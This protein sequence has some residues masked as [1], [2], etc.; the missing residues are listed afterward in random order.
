LFHRGDI[1]RPWKSNLGPWSVTNF[2]QTQLLMQIHIM[3]TQDDPQLIMAP[4]KPFLSMVQKSAIDLYNRGL[5]VFPVCRPEI[6]IALANLFPNRW[7]PN[8]KLPFLLQR[9]FFSRL[10]LCNSRCTQHQKTSGIICRG[11]RPGSRFVDLFD[12]TNLGVMLGRTSGNLVCVDCD[13]QIAFQTMLKEFT[14]RGLNFW[15]YNT[16]RGGNLLFRLAEGEAANAKTCSVLRVEI[17]GHRHFCVLPPSIHSSGVVYTWLDFTDPAWHL[18][19]NEPPPILHIEQLQWLGIELYEDRKRSINLF[20]LPDWTLALSENNRRILASEI[21]EGARNTLLTKAVYDIAAAIIDGMV[22]YPEAVALLDEAASRCLPPYPTSSIHQMLRTALGKKDIAP[23][24]QYYSKGNPNLIREPDMEGIGQFQETYDWKSHGRTAL[25]DRSVFI[26]CI[27]RSRREGSI[28]FRA[29]A[30]EIANLANIQDPHT[31]IA[32]LQRLVKKGILVPE[33]KDESGA[34]RYKFSEQVLFPNPHTNFHLK[35]SVWIGKSRSHPI[36]NPTASIEQDIFL[37]L[38]KA[39]WFVWQH[40]LEKAEPGP[41]E[42]AR[43]LGLLPGTVFRALMK[44]KDHGLVY[45]S[46]S[47]GLY[48]GEN[49]IPESLIDIAAKIGTEGK[50]TRRVEAFLK[51]REIFTNKTLEKEIRRIDGLL[52]RGQRGAKQEV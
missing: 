52:D 38:G 20:G 26:A 40:L 1:E 37:G 4:T 24:R 23:S 30:R 12:Y 16:S 10:H 51:D 45:Y 22:G 3:E 42:I 27:E 8:Q 43:A 49:M 15:A 35:N 48:F 28:T 17:W 44:L 32:A 34:A 6:V 11:N 50:S 21:P 2:K 14:G 5:N 18:P 41:S 39:A 19:A 31:S 36:Q 9:L 7:T 29:S 25:T 33:E 47:E 13:E 46:K